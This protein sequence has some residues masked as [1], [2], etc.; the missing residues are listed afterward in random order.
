MHIDTSKMLVFDTGLMHFSNENYPL[1]QNL[2]A[3]EPFCEWH[4]S[5]NLARGLLQ[6]DAGI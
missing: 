2:S 3:F 4:V 5:H 1:H 6:K